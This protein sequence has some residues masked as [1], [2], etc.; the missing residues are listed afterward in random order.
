MNHPKNS[1]P[2]PSTTHAPLTRKQLLRLTQKQ[3]AN[4]KQHHIQ[5]HAA[6]R[7]Y[8]DQARTN[9]R[10]NLKFLKGTAE[11][12]LKKNIRTIRRLFNG[13][14]VWKDE[15]TTNESSKASSTNEFSNLQWENLPNAI[16][17]NV[18]N[19]LTTLQNYLHKITN[20][21]I[22]SP[23]LQDGTSS[24]SIATR[25]QQFYRIKSQQPV[26]MDNAWIVKNV[27]LALLPGAVIHVFCSY[28]QEEMKEFYAELEKKERERVFGSS[29]SNDDGGDVSPKNDN[30][31]GSMG[32]SSVL[33]AEGGGTWDKLK[34]A[35]NDLFLGG[36]EDKVRVGVD[37]TATTLDSD[38]NSTPSREASPSLETSEKQNIVSEDASSDK[39]ATIQALL[40]RIQALEKQVGIEQHSQAFSTKYEMDR[41]NQPPMRNRRDDHMISQ[42]R[43]LEEEKKENESKNH[44]E[45][46]TLQIVIDGAKHYWSTLDVD[47]L[48]E[49]V[50]NKLVDLADKLPF[51]QPDDETVTDAGKTAVTNSGESQ[52]STEVQPGANN[53]AVTSSRGGTN[54]IPSEKNEC[55]DKDNG[56]AINQASDTDAQLNE[57]VTIE[58]ARD[59]AQGQGRWRKWW[60]RISPWQRKEESIESSR[61]EDNA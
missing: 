34:M 31:S 55:V 48:M 50:H 6:S 41:K 10:T 12:N 54:P 44:N 27:L 26:V 7:T 28:K 21:I 9:I 57:D 52:N 17:S 24:G 18:Q 42:W 61:P 16:K 32:L 36:V 49:W 22:P 45:S 47:S 8:L 23:N 37:G 46:S 38:R 35:V 2:P 3:R 59:K 30:G 25:L 5:Q 14:E 13:E 43:K 33:V 51:A 29:G 15:V 4:L 58:N 20:G 53:A 39:D 56:N 60:S 19:N 1:K 40:E 11:S